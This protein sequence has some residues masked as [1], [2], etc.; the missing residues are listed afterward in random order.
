MDE[1]IGNVVHNN[2]TFYPPTTQIITYSFSVQLFFFISG[3]L[4]HQEISSSVFI[5]KNIR[6]LLIP[7][8]IWGAIMLV[9]YNLKQMDIG[10]LIHSVEGLLL[11]F[12]NFIDA[13]GCGELWFIVTLLWLKIIVQITKCRRI[14]LLFLPMSIFCAIV[15]KNM[16]M[17]TQFNYWGIGMFNVFVAY[18]FFYIGYFLSNYKKEILKVSD[19]I[20]KLPFIHFL[21]LLG[22]MAVLCLFSSRNGLVHMVYGGYGKNIIL[23]LIFGL[24]GIGCMFFLSVGMSK[25]NGMYRYIQDINVGSIM[26]LGIHIGFVNKIRMSLVYLFGDEGWIFELS[27]IIAS[28]LLLFLFIPMINFVKKYFP[29]S[30]GYRN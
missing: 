13:R 26:I 17:G 29:I 18:P 12:N 11:G 2:R 21:I 25:I 4:F 3:F 1:G 15:Y 22:L 23:Y 6:S 16:I 5:R 8:Y 14:L 27:I 28:L 24:I 7:Y 10:V 30:M 19:S 20:M 9:F